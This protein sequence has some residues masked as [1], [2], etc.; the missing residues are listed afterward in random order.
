MLTQ[1]ACVPPRSP[2][3]VKV[4]NEVIKPMLA[5]GEPIARCQFK[6]AHNNWARQTLMRADPPLFDVRFGKSVR[7]PNSPS[8]VL[9][10]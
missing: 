2:A 8:S 4:V 9:V 3:Y 7:E 6:I 10:E 1:R 5:D